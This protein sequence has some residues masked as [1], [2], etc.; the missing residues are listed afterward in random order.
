MN[1]EKEHSQYKHL[2]RRMLY[3]MAIFAVLIGLAITFRNISKPSDKPPPQNTPTVSLVD[4]SEVISDSVAYE[5]T[6]TTEGSSSSLHPLPQAQ[7]GDSM[8]SYPP[9]PTSPPSYPGPGQ[10]MVYPTA[11]PTP[12]PVPSCKFDG[13]AP[14][15]P[16][17]LP[18]LDDFYF[19]EPKV[20]FKNNAPI[21]IIQ[22]LPD[23]KRVL[24]KRVVDGKSHVETIDIT[25]G[26]S[27][28]Y[29]EN[30]FSVD[31]AVWLENE[32][33]VAFI[34]KGNNKK[35]Y[36]GY[37][38]D[39]SPKLV[40]EN[41]WGTSLSAL[42]NGDKLTF[43]SKASPTYPR[44]L[45]L[46]THKIM[47]FSLKQVAP[48][49]KKLEKL[50][51]FW[52]TYQL[53]WQP[54]GNYLAY[55]NLYAFYL[56]NTK[57]SEVCELTIKERKIE[58]EKP[59]AANAYWSPNGRYLAVFN[60]EGEPTVDFIDLTIIDTHTGEYHTIELDSRWMNKYDMVWHPNS[61]SFIVFAQNFVNERY[62]KLYLFDFMTKKY[63]EILHDY[64][65][66]RSGYFGIDW[67]S[68]GKKLSFICPTPISEN[69][70]GIEQWSICI[71]E[72]DYGK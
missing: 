57:T 7:T 32:Q 36:L 62:H 30:I 53:A 41:I 49:P 65:F 16:K 51:N 21:D 40:A 64:P 45:D 27:M 72:V 2:L 69:R 42:P 44:L 26:K 33:A 61:Y 46:D 4:F 59:W 28:K 8:A 17:E 70:L 9:P 24:V 43:F 12:I 34:T 58:M 3:P 5:L 23:D 20:I 47:P 38:H 37:G 18:S 25:N 19:W 31:S 14:S 52:D 35:L 6:P 22:W 71:L 54:Q 55:Y 66:L 1:E 11:T 10:G 67:S 39:K 68:D 15:V 60:T 48:L 13:T 50:T 63:K 29:G 56:A